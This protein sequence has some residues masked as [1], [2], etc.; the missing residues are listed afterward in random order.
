MWNNVVESFHHTV[1]HKPASGSDARLTAAAAAASTGAF[2][3][4][5]T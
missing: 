2:L 1:S 4:M 3:A 5:R